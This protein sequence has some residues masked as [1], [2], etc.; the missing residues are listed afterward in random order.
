M[1]KKNIVL[2][3]FMGSGKTMTA[4]KLAEI[5]GSR[6]IST[7]Q[8]IEDR[9]GRAITKIFE[10]LGEAYFR[11]LEKDVIA[12][13]TLQ[14]GVIL[15]CGGGAV[16]DQENIKNLRKNGLI[17]YLSASPESI[18]ENIKDHSSRP[19]LNVEDPLKRIGELLGQRKLLYEQADIV[20]DADHRSIDQITEDILKVLKN[21]KF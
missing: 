10:E 6:V 16:L 15:D 12:E 17:I 14:N 4:N 5:L 1:A 11:K 21:E 9:E 19:L 3:G 20:I 13:I 8:V 7:D 2:V 18:Y